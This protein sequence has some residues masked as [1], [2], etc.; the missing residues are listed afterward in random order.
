MPKKSPSGISLTDEDWQFVDS[1][2]DATGAANASAYFALLVDLDRRF[3][4]D[5][6]PHLSDRKFHLFPEGSWA[7]EWKW[8][9]AGPAPALYV[10]RPTADDLAAAESASPGVT[11]IKSVDAV[12]QELHRQDQTGGGIGKPRPAKP[13]SPP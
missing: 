10:Q 1:R 12:R 4:F 3:R 2:L 6:H 5:A 7:L 8:H 13:G 11:L 9:G